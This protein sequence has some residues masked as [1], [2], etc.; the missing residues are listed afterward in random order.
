MTV[1]RVPIAFSVNGQDVTV[2]AMPVARASA[3]L[4]DQLGLTGT[5]VGWTRATAAPAPFD[6]RRLRLP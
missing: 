3:V 6:R 5:K 2:D 1:D 4:R